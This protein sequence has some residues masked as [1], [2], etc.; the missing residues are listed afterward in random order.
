MKTGDYMIHVSLSYPCPSWHMLTMLFHFIGLHRQWQK[1]QERRLVS[2]FSNAQNFRVF[3][4]FNVNISN[5][6]NS[7]V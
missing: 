6:P 3:L 7:F 4:D 1:F 5:V 2:Y